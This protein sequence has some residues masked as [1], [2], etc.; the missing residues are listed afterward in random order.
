MRPRQLKIIYWLV[1]SV[2][3]TPVLHKVFADGGVPYDGGPHALE[4]ARGSAA[5]DREP[6]RA[7]TLPRVITA[8]S[9]PSSTK[10]FSAPD[11][12]AG[13]SGKP[14]P[15]HS[16]RARTGR[17]SFYAD[18]F[19]GR[20]MADGTPM[21]LGGDNAASR[22][23]PLGTRALVTNLETGRRAVVTIQDRGPYI[24]GRIVDLSPATA[25]AIGLTRTQ[26]I[27]LVE[28]APIT[29]PLPDGRVLLG[30]GAAVSALN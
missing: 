14:A 20:T 16:G 7:G 26:G 23:L 27:T 5:G 11:R 13:R 21:D 8:P 2:A 29:V 25:T 30:E 19:G 4:A 18:R 24:D 15:D 28:V 1:V 6:W 9:D 12:A 22:T 10:A 17:A 3:C